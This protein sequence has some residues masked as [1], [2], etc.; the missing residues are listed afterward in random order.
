MKFYFFHTK[1][2]TIL[3][4]IN[5]LFITACFTHNKI[6][7]TDCAT[8]YPIVFVHGI[9]YRD[10]IRILKYWSNIPNII[11]QNGGRAFLSNQNAFNSHIE[12]AI[13]I[14]DRI[15]EILDKTKSDKVNIIAHSKGG[16][17]AR[18]LISKLNMADKVASLTTISTPHRGSSIADTIIAFL[19][20]K[21]LTKKAQNLA[22]FYAKLIGD[23]NPKALKAANDLTVTYMKYF[24]K[25]VLNMPQVYYQS[26]GSIINSNYPL[27]V[28]KIQN[29]MMQKA[30][31]SNDGIVSSYSYKWGNFRGIVKSNENYGISHFDIVG[32]KFI[33]KSSSF[34]A[35][36][37][38]YEIAK[39]LKVKGY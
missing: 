7:S 35:E 8:K 22:N 30:E 17:E 12:N 32:M 25:S 5:I 16:L 27:W 28:V 31:G 37:F 20:R 4:L 19:Q 13:L 3:L 26:Y 1:V 10:D 36:K 33:S 6:Q 39:D 21:K 14:K 23:K 34:D 9:A 29:K 38:I 2:L 11:K 15:I 24:N 18:Y